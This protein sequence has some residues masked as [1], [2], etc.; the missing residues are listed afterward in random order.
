[1]STNVA[2]RFL[3]DFGN[4]KAIMQR[5]IDFHTQSDG[6]LNFEPAFRQADATLA[7]FLS[8]AHTTKGYFFLSIM[9]PSTWM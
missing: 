6:K 5:L 3:N 2:N 9:E 8:T 4:R 7:K 1:M